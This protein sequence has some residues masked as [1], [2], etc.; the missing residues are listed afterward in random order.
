MEELS[1]YYRAAY[2]CGIAIFL[3]VAIYLSVQVG[4]LKNLTGE[5]L[6]FSIFIFRRVGTR[7]TPDVPA[8]EKFGAVYH[9]LR[10]VQHSARGGRVT[11]MPVPP[12]AS[13]TSC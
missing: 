9:L 12:I 13:S 2:C 6:I 7:S 8:S 10:Q 3:L 1:H 5:Y 4:D 11:A